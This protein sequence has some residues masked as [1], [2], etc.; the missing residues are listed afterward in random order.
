MQ[1]FFIQ[2]GHRRSP[3]NF[4]LIGG[5]ELRWPQNKTGVVDRYQA[6]MSHSGLNINDGGLST[7]AI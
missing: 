1:H 6:T 4:F 2:R 7:V 3:A 5:G